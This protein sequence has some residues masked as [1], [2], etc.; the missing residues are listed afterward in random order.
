MQT[1]AKVLD[2]LDLFLTLDKDELSFREIVKASGLK[3]STAHRIIN[4]LINRNFLKRQR[5]IGRYTLGIHLLE[6]THILNNEEKGT[7]SNGISYLVE[8][9]K[10]INISVFIQIWYGSEV[11]FSKALDSSEKIPSDWIRMPLHQTCVG[12]IALANLSEEDYKKYFRRAEIAKATHKTIIDIDK[13]KKELEMVKLDG[14]AFEI[15]ERVS[16]MSG[17]AAG[18]K[19][20]YGEVI[21]AVFLMGDSRR[22]THEVLLKLVNS[23]KIGADNISRELGYKF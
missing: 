5:K 22:F 18:I 9:S 19:N 4:T 20:S 8:L 1:T 14:V 16:K 7:R 13:M 2:V 21:G 3:R 12:K 23:L 6:L 17:I 11:L 10:L 15:G